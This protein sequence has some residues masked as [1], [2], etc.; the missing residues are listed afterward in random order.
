MK[1]LAE[2]SDAP[3]H[4]EFMQQLNNSWRALRQSRLDAKF[5]KPVSDFSGKS[6]FKK[7][8]EDT[9]IVFEHELDDDYARNGGEKSARAKRAAA[10][11]EQEISKVVHT[12]D[13][14]QDRHYNTFGCKCSGLLLLTILSLLVY[15]RFEWDHPML[16]QVIRMG[17]RA[18]YNRNSMGP[19]SYSNPK[20]RR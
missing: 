5:K 13:L 16:Q 19:G 6:S 2:E 15:K 9:S 20:V 12:H 7:A 1:R 11:Q 18:T 4:D 8:T 3:N 14:I 10:Q 17:G